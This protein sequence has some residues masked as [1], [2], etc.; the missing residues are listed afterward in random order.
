LSLLGMI[1]LMLGKKIDPLVAK[2]VV[3]QIESDVL[4]TQQ[5]QC[6]TYLIRTSLTT[7]PEKKLAQLIVM[8]HQIDTNIEI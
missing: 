3:K 1:E 8:W 4:L 2:V 6:G 7:M 5:R